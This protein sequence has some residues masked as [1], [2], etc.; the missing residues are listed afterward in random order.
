[1][2]SE[3]KRFQEILKLCRKSAGWSADYLGNRLN[4]TK[5][6][7]YNIESNNTK[8]S[9]AQYIAIRYIFDE[10]AKL[11]PERFMITKIL[12]DSIVDHPESYSEYE[13]TLIKST[14]ILIPARTKF[15]TSE[16]AH[17]FIN[18]FISFLS[19]NG[20]VLKH[21]STDWLHNLEK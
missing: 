9:T 16:E 17:Q 19:N 11:D 18:V 5:Q 10:E 20:I 4:L 21:V 14:I 12:L 1:M 3:I 6:Q 8:L 13:T 2:M 7:I 15:K